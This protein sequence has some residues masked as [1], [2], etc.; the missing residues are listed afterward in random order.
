MIQFAQPQIQTKCSGD[1]DKMA[2][3]RKAGVPPPGAP[4]GTK[5]KPRALTKKDK[6]EID[7][8][9]Q[10]CLQLSA[11]SKQA[12]LKKVQD[13]QAKSRDTINQL[14]VSNQQDMEGIENQK[15]AFEDAKKD[16]EKADASAKDIQLR[17]TA[18]LDASLAKFKTQIEGRKQAVEAQNKTR[19][20][21]IQD[22]LLQEQNVKPKYSTI[23][24][25]ID[26]RRQAQTDFT[27]QCCTGTN[28]DNRCSQVQQG[29]DQINSIFGGSTGVGAGP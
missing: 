13:D 9:Y 24:A 23:P 5:A 20:K 6:N 18:R 11:L 26:A 22:L 25:T 15:K 17:T 1:A 29:A 21:M 4:Y 19:M 12:E 27:T 2:S 10:T 3:D 7:L 28:D 14:E 8:A 16:A